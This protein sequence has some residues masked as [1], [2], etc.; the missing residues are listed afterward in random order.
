MFEAQGISVRVSRQEMSISN[1]FRLPTILLF[2]NGKETK[3]MT[4]SDVQ[5]LAQLTDRFAQIAESAGSSVGS[6]VVSGVPL[7]R[8]YSDVT[9]EIEIKG[10]DLLNADGEF[11]SVRNLFSDNK[12]SGGDS[13]S[14]GKGK[15][16]A[17]AK[18][19]DWVES[20]TDAQLMIFVPFQ[21][22]IKLHSLQIT[23]FADRD[24][25]EDDD[26]IPARPQRIELYTNRPHTLGFEEAEDIP[27]T[28]VIELKAEDWDT[29][30]KT[31]TVEL[32]F[33]KFQNITSLVI[34]VV[35]AEGGGE[36]T[37]ID[38]IRLVGESGEKRTMG[39]LQKVGE[40]ES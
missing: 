1:R 24:E 30:T 10:M 12:P 17:D 4:G 13:S 40:D 23:S 34:F 25:D 8:G 35:D 26:E 7:P 27:A 9:P 36:R 29:K 19:P 15:A 31:A 18:S 37:R 3:R 2:E 32:R 33:V 16:K 28:Q 6:S 14:G 38:R 11:G 21:S 39:K 20:D 5:G 22:T